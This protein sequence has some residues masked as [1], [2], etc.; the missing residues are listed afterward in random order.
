MEEVTLN[1]LVGNIDEISKLND[2]LYKK[3]QFIYL[4]II[5]LQGKK[6][7]ENEFIEIFFNYSKRK[8]FLYDNI[9]IIE[10]VTEEENL[11]KIIDTYNEYFEIESQ[12]SLNKKEIQK[13]FSFIEESINNFRNNNIKESDFKILELCIKYAYNRYKTNKFEE[14]FSFYSDSMNNSLYS[15]FNVNFSIDNKRIWH[16]LELPGFFKTLKK[17]YDVYINNNMSVEDFIFSNVSIDLIKKYL[18]DLPMSD[19]EERIIKNYESNFEKK[20]CEKIKKD[21]RINIALMISKN[22]NFSKVYEYKLIPEIILGYDTPEK[23]YDPQSTI[24]GKKKEYN[25]YSLSSAN[26]SIKNY[27]KKNVNYLEVDYQEL[28]ESNKKIYNCI[29]KVFNHTEIILYMNNDNKIIGILDKKTNIEFKVVFEKG[30]YTFKSNFNPNLFLVSYDKKDIF[31]DIPINIINTYDALFYTLIHIC[32]ELNLSYEEINKFVNNLNFESLEYTIKSKSEVVKN[33]IDKKT[34]HNLNI[35]LFIS[36]LAN[37]TED[38]YNNENSNY[39]MKK[40]D[41]IIDKLQKEEIKK[42]KKIIEIAFQKNSIT[43]ILKEQVVGYSVNGSNIPEFGIFVPLIQKLNELSGKDIYYEK[44]IGCIGYCIRF[45]NDGTLNNDSVIELYPKTFMPKNISQLEGDLRINGTSFLLDT[46]YD[47]KTK[48]VYN[49][50]LISEKDGGLKI[51]IQKKLEE[52]VN[53]KSKGKKPKK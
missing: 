14:E 2:F 4:Y 50:T 30:E 24:N 15:G 52:I 18:L 46:I 8:S 22:I 53:K 7:N 29:N 16:L 32:K 48:K 21:L 40:K 12:I 43:D 36:L 23:N 38:D 3:F 6:Y 19:I 37:I 27:S 11:K 31:E 1:S 41:I 5:F 45:N 28:D 51:S 26:T 39:E 49:T 13:T 34:K 44:N 35:E 9:N 42:L 25:Y 17:S 33:I 47:T 20:D 10:N